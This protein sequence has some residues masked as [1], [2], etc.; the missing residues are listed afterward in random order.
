MINLFRMLLLDI[1]NYGRLL[2]FR[3]R[4]RKRNGSNTTIASS[5]F[6]M[7]KVSVG[8]YT[9]GKINVLDYSKCNVKLYIGSYCSIGPNVTF[10]LAADHYSNTLTTFPLKAKILYIDDK[11]ALSKGDIIIEDDVWIGLNVTICSGVRIG[12][13]AIIAAGSV[14]TRDIPKYSISG[15]VPAKHIKYRHDDETISS[16]LEMDIVEVL[17]RANADSI[18]K[19][20]KVLDSNSIKEF[21]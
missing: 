15:G 3:W 2:V 10:L 11:E 21:F 12:Q 7:N 13:G 20:Y 4:W 16:L 19:Y 9:Y 5:L 14:V 17:S 8:K 18:D 1:V 6:D